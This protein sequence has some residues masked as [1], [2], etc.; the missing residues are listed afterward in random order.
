MWFWSTTSNVSLSLRAARKYLW[1]GFLAVATLLQPA[2]INAFELTGK[3]VSVSDGDTI[4]VLDQEQRSHKV[5]LS[6]IDAPEKRQP[7]G[8]QSKQALSNVVF[9]QT[10]TVEGVKQAFPVLKNRVRRLA[11]RPSDPMLLK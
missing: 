9:G 3:V 10:V 2:A 1:A 11:R 4:T 7:L 8:Q 5:R 6:G